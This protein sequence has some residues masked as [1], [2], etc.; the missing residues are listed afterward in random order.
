MESGSLT[1]GEAVHAIFAGE[2]TINAALQQLQQD[3]SCQNK[4][5]VVA[6]MSAAQL[7][8]AAGGGGTQLGGGSA[9]SIRAPKRLKL[10][11]HA[12]TI[13]PM[14]LTASKA[15][16]IE[17]RLTRGSNLIL[18]VHAVVL[19][20][21]HYGLRL[22]VP[23]SSSKTVLRLKVNFI[24]GTTPVSRSITLVIRTA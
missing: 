16:I 8:T 10:H 3:V 17:L 5:R 11:E 1:Y 15:G 2:H 12:S 19:R 18:N 6:P 23:Q 13:L 20:S 14:T 21:D 22:A 7:S 4:A 24:A 9:L